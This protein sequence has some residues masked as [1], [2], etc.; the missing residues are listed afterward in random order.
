MTRWSEDTDLGPLSSVSQAELVYD[1]V[2]RSISEGAMLL[3]GGVRDEA[4]FEPTILLEVMPGMPA[5]DEEVFR[6]CFFC[7][8]GR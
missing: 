5:F 4:F 3:T 6:S 7:N 1:Q 8:P 2:V